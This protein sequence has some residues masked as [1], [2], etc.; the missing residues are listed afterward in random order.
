MVE[1]EVGYTNPHVDRL[2][3]YQPIDADFNAIYFEGADHSIDLSTQVFNTLVEQVRRPEVSVVVLTGDA[4]HGKTHLCAKLLAELSGVTIGDVA[5]TINED[6]YGVRDMFVMPDGRPLRIIKDLSEAPPSSGAELLKIAIQSD[7]V[8]VVCANEGR[9]RSCLNIAGLDEMLRSLQQSI[10]NGRGHSHNSPHVIIN[11][12]HQSVSA[13]ETHQPVIDQLFS[14]WLLDDSKWSACGGCPASEECPIFRNSTELAGDGAFSAS[15]RDAIRLL[16]SVVERIG[17]TVT[18]RELLIAVSHFIT[19]GISCAAVQAMAK[20]RSDYPWQLNYGFASNV[21]GLNVTGTSMDEMQ[22][23]RGLRKLDPALIAIRDVDDRLD[24]ESDQD[25]GKFGRPDQSAIQ[26]APTTARG[27]EEEAERHRGL[28]HQMRR[29]GFFQADLLAQA[30]GGPPDAKD[31]LG[32]SNIKEFEA[33][34]AG[35]D[36]PKLKH[37]L[38]RGLEAVQ[39][40]QRSASFAP[41]VI[42]DPAFTTSLSSQVSGSVLLP[43]TTSIVAVEVPLSDISIRSEHDSWKAR[44][45]ESEAPTARDDVDWLDRRIILSLDPRNADPRLAIDLRLHEFE[46]LLRAAAGLQSRQHFAPTIQSILRRL[47]GVVAVTKPTDHV[48]LYQSG[49]RIALHLDGNVIHRLEN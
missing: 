20:E 10:V 15:R 26:P 12:N 48:V 3:R 39:G 18:I 4:G 23:F 43:S 6:G 11:L 31:R 9:L 47:A 30:E 44:L 22:V 14:A 27:R 7:A 33:V 49:R 19:G 8:T 35:E 40:I 32:F 37:R 17:F 24:P 34:A 28:W 25:L 42:V 29:R 41:F 36:V 21:F 2:N 13:S 46:Y 5:G 38:L 16:L 45:P 1:V